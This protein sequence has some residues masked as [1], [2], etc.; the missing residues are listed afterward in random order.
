MNSRE[1]MITFG[2]KY[3][4]QVH[5]PIMINNSLQPCNAQIIF[6]LVFKIEE[7]K[8]PIF[9]ITHFYHVLIIINARYPE[10]LYLYSTRT[11]SIVNRNV[12]KQ[13]FYKTISDEISLNSESQ[14]QQNY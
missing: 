10:T 8:G 12:G 2:T 13:P 1:S 3:Y 7:I 9:H 4:L 14:L 11:D 5:F 6:I